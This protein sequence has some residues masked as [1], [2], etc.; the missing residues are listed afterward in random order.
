[1]SVLDVGCGFG[2]WGMLLR[3]Y[4]DLWD[5]RYEY[6]F[7]RTIDAVEVFSDYITPLHRY[8][9]NKIYQQNVL[10]IADSLKGYDLILII[11]TL[12]H[13]EKL[14]G[15][16]LL[17]TLLSN[18][19][20]VLVS[21]PK[22]WNAQTAGFGNPFEE[23]KCLWTYDEFKEIANSEFIEDSNSIICYLSK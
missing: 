14:Q 15:K 12:E 13:F 19:K 10:E 23:H 6:S 4:L 5:G 18:N 1:M 17:G 11:G 3:E 21:T 8:I 7:K 2:K 20:G 9:Y 22:N 16:R